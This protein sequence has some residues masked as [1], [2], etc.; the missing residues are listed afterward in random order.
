M[1]SIQTQDSRSHFADNSPRFSQNG[2]RTEN[3]RPSMKKF[4]NAV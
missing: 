2:N 1:F 4:R 3:L